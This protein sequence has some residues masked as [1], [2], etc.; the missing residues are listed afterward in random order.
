VHLLLLN[1]WRVPG[2]RLCAMELVLDV[3]CSIESGCGVY[4]WELHARSMQPSLIG[5][6][7]L[8]IGYIRASTRQN[9][10]VSMFTTFR[11]LLGLVTAVVETCPGS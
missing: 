1:L 8:R 4:H 11:C 2:C 5:V 7:S 9:V 6:Y 10:A 3:G